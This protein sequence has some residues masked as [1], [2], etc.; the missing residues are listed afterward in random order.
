MVKQ[1]IGLVGLSNSVYM[2]VHNSNQHNAPLMQ[3][4]MLRL[5][6]HCLD[7]QNAPLIGNHMEML[8]FFCWY[9]D[10]DYYMDII[11]EQMNYFI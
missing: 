10:L 6:E 11:L 2:K 5:R 1:C 7:N 8:W 3:I 4:W 9:F